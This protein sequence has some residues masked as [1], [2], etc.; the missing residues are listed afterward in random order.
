LTLSGGENFKL[1]HHSVIG[2]EGEHLVGPF[3]YGYP[4]LGSRQVIHDPEIQ[5]GGRVIDAVQVQV[6]HQKPPL[7]F[8]HK[9]E[10]GAVDLLPGDAQSGAQSFGE[11][12]FAAA[13]F[14][15]ERDD[16]AGLE[17]LAHPLAK[18]PR[19]RRAAGDQGETRLAHLTSL[20]AMS[21]R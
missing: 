10:G 15:D 20:A 13:E 14:S 21:F 2:Q 17:P 18:L 5:A 11:A 9:G 4:L 16:A 1:H 6:E 19:G 12:R 7:V 8:I 3:Y